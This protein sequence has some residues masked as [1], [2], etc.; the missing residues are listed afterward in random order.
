M[1]ALPALAAALGAIRARVIQHRVISIFRGSPSRRQP[2][3]ASRRARRAVCALLLALAAPVLA[4]SP[5]PEIPTAAFGFTYRLPPGWKSASPESTLPAARENALQSA[6]NPSQELGIACAQVVLSAES[7]KTSSA[8]VVAALPYACY[9]Q[10][11]SAKDLPGFAAG[12]SD[13]LKQNL[14]ISVPVYGSYTL[15]THNFWI[16][17]AA[18]VPKNRPQSVYTVEIACSLLK[19]SAVCWMTLAAGAGALRDFENTPVELDGEPPVSL[20][21]VDAFVKKTHPASP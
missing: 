16:E 1:S 12:V 21:P 7:E 6:K 9:G 15:G 17:R 11:M 14:N 2:S 13:G 10:P 8:I 20:V 5:S 3:P 4:Q 18:G 19:K